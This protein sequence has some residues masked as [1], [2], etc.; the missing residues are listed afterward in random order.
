MAYS[1]QIRLLVLK[2]V[3]HTFSCSN[4]HIAFQFPYILALLDDFIQIHTLYD[5]ALVQTIILPKDSSPICFSQSSFPYEITN[6]KGSVM[7]IILTTAQSVIVFKLNSRESQID[8]AI[9][10]GKIDRALKLAEEFIEF[11]MI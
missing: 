4:Q 7:K 5:Q 8:N 11:D 9:S 6:D 2:F 10:S 1:P 3:I